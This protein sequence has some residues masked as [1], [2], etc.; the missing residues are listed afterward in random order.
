MA[1]A[2]KVVEVFTLENRPFF[3]PPVLS[4]F[5]IRSW[6]HPS[7]TCSTPASCGDQSGPSVQKD[8]ASKKKKKLKR[9]GRKKEEE[10]TRKK[11]K[12]R[13]KN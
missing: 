11:T 13:K 12:R 1:R 8:K 3:E 6:R 2:R 7:G 9:G 4:I 10:V 5:I